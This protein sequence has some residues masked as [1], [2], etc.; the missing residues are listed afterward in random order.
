MAYS[1]SEAIVVRGKLFTTGR[2]SRSIGTSSIDATTSS[3]PLQMSHSQFR[4]AEAPQQAS[5]GSY[6]G[7]RAA[8]LLFHFYHNYNNYHNYRNYLNN[9]YCIDHT[10]V[11]HRCSRTIP[12][13]R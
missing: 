11:W 8:M 6:M 12:L 7:D 10:S 5:K 2:E 13:A 3:F 4:P 9:K 1:Q